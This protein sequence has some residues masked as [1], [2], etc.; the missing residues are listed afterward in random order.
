MAVVRNA[1]E[2]VAD[3]QGNMPWEPLTEHP[4]TRLLLSPSQVLPR[5]TF[6]EWYF[7]QLFAGGNA[8]AEIRRAR[9]TRTPMELVPA[10]IVGSPLIV[11]D[12]GFVL[13]YP[14]HTMYSKEERRIRA[15][16][17]LNM[18]GPDFDYTE[19]QSSSP[20]SEAA[21]RSLIVMEAA[22][23][24]Q[25]VMLKK[26][27]LG[28]AITAPYEMRNLGPEKLKELNRMVRKNL[29]AGRKYD[30]PPILAPGYETQR[31]TG[32]SA[33]D[34]QLVEIL[35]W[36][37]EDVARVW[38]V[39]LSW[40]HHFRG[41]ISTAQNS[42]NSWSWFLSRSIRGHCIRCQEALTANLVDMGSQMR[43]LG[44]RL[45]W[46]ALRVRDDDESQ[47]NQ[48]TDSSAEGG[49]GD[50]PPAGESVP[51]WIPSDKSSEPAGPSN[52][53]AQHRTTQVLS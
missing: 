29:R 35:R 25:S 32:M 7:T 33:A 8:Y 36:T 40:L 11:R 49:P 48:Q 22:L 9:N 19:M 45:N 38:N 50:A 13:N 5:Y 26:V 23:D 30:D 39:P 41:G 21:K 10:N 46:P 1:P 52:G 17:M 31:A 24:H 16:N 27:N 20:V 44:V 14:S 28:V 37:I 51:G 34:I 2:V 4:V 47:R 3:E 43:G 53:Q 12:R 42:D 15:A 18:H 6:W